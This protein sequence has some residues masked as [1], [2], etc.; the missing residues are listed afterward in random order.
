MPD[1]LST[2][3]LQERSQRVQFRAEAAPVTGLQPSDCVVVVAERVAGP[4]VGRTC[5]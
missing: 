1:I 3:F 5:G 2:Q 4:T